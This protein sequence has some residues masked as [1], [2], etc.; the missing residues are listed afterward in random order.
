MWSYKTLDNRTGMDTN[1]VTTCTNKDTLILNKTYRMYSNFNV[2]TA[3]T[4]TS[5]FSNVGSDYYE[6]ASLSDQLEPFEMKYL[7][8]NATVGESWTN[9]LNSTASGANISA[10]IKNTIEAK[11]G[12]LMIGTNTYNNLIQVK[13]E[14]INANLQINVPPFGTQNITPTI[15]QDV[16]SYFAPKFG[17]VKRDYKLK[18]SAGLFGQTSTIID[19]DKSTTLT[20]STVQ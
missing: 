17:L 1:I 16:H 10:T 2:E 5:L 13:T 4:D 8:T 6:L 12:S 7:S 3:Q 15:I 11:G 20:S 9:T 19:A 18:I 14:I